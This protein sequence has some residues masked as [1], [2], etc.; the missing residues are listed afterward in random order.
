MVMIGGVSVGEMLD[1][2]ERE[3]ESSSETLLMAGTDC[4]VASDLANV[5]SDCGR[6]PP[7]G[8]GVL[9]AAA[10]ARAP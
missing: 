6:T 5:R 1:G 7:V 9:A 10:S 2:K 8:G 4:E 3:N